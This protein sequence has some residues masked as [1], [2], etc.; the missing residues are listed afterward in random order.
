MGRGAD[1]VAAL[2]RG[3]VILALAAALMASAA[4]LG[5]AQGRPG[6]LRSLASGKCVDL[7]AGET[8][9]GTELIQYDCHGGPNQQWRIE[10]LGDAGVRIISAMTGKCVGTKPRR[11][12]GG[13][14]VVKVACDGSLGELWSV[15]DDGNGYVLQNIA[16]RLCIDVLGASNANGT[17]LLGWRCTGESNQTWRYGSTIAP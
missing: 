12:G 9:D 6:T 3:A 10:S 2:R 4:G 16:S 13:A 5:F 7:P 1:V 8:G 17:K 15:R 14:Y 11:S